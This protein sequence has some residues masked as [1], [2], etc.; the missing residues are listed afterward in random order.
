ME[1]ILFYEGRWYFF[2]S[3]S[4]FMVRWRD[5]D[6]TTAE[7]AYQAAKFDDPDIVEKIRR[8]RSAHDAKKIAHAHD[9]KRIANWDDIKVGIMEGIVRA[10]LEQHPYIR[11]KLLETGKAE[12]VEDSPSDSFWGRGRDWKGENHLGKIWM[13]LRD[14]TKL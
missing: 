8:A 10:K 9:E 5:S 1:K 12:I 11:R 4:A 14:E 6:W 7:H 2:S 13:K 3:F